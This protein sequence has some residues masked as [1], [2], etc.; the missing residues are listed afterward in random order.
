MM[1][2]LLELYRQLDYLFKR[3]YSAHSFNVSYAL[4]PDPWRVFDRPYEIHKADLLLEVV[5]RR[6][7]TNAID[8]GCGPGILTKRLASHCDHLL[9]LDFSPR[10]ISLA[11]ARCKDDKH[12]SFVAEDIRNIELSATYD[13]FVCA[14]ILFYLT[15]QDIDR[16]IE[17]IVKH[18]ATDGWLVGVG[19]TSGYDA[20]VFSRLERRFRLIDRLEDRRWPRPFAV[21]LFGIRDAQ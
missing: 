6:R 14:E 2:F 8:I 10:A 17:K 19:S 18:S 21:S 20:K 15:M 16:V 11:Q 9:G 7:H 13:L 1:K 12:V 4:D 3:S 5:A